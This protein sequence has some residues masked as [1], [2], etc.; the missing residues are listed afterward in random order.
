[1]IER[2]NS[3]WIGER[4]G[5]VEKLCLVSA[6]SHGHSFTLYSYSPDTL[7]GVPKGIELR[8]AREVMAIE[9]LLRCVERGAVALGADLFRYELLANNFGYWVDMDFCFLKPID[10]TGPYVFGWESD[11]KI[12]N[13]LLRIPYNSNM[14]RDL[15]SLPQPNRKPPWF[16]PKRSMT[17]YWNW[18]TKGNIN[19]EDLPWGTFGPEMVTYLAKKYGV[20][21]HA[22]PPEV[23]YPVKWQDAG[24]FLGPAEVVEAAITPDTRAVHLYHARLADCNRLPPPKGSFLDVMCCKYGI[25]TRC[26]TE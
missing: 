12:N 19:V 17:Y 2:L 18:L 6:L 15:R 14:V 10:F 4:L 20:A 8:D 16:G 22:Q 24:L 23:F 7:R 21:H 11:A 25:D 13:A 5:F 26:D 3:L 9:K 1:M